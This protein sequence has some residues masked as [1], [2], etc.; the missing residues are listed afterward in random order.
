MIPEILL[1]N[2][3][4]LLKTD[5]CLVLTVLAS[6]A[7]L[8]AL[9]GELS[10]VPLPPLILVLQASAAMLPCPVCYMGAEDSNL[11][12]HPCRTSVLAYQTISSTLCFYFETGSHIAQISLKL[13]VAEEDLELL[14]LL[15]LLPQSW[16]YRR[17]PQCRFIQ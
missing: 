9:S 3:C 1:S 12:P 5:I 2:C 4:S 13:I 17:A 10:V 14:A 16:D 15:H 8:R 11:G 6:L 7:G